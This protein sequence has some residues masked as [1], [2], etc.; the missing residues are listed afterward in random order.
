MDYDLCLSGPVREL[1]SRIAILS[2]PQALTALSD[3]ELDQWTQ[4]CSAM[5]AR[6]GRANSAY[7]T[8]RQLLSDA[9]AEHA[10]RRVTRQADRATMT[11]TIR[12]R[13]TARLAGERRRPPVHH[14]GA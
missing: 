11:A 3:P 8:W 7:R 9:D 10:A 1:A 13:S 12:D 4:T 6:P 2:S 14:R 5:V